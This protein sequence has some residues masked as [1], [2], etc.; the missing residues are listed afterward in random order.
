VNFNFEL[1]KKAR[2]IAGLSQLQ[3]ADALG[4]SQVAVS[5][6]E[7]GTLPISHD[8]EYEIYRVFES[9]GLNKADV[10]LL[11]YVLQASKA[12]RGRN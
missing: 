4:V 12:A 2:Q 8:K 3:L 1:L 6:W 5:K 11:G 10:Q 7:A 9:H